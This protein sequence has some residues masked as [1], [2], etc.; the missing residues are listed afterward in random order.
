MRQLLTQGLR[1]LVKGD[2][3]YP[4]GQHSAAVIAVAT[5]KGGVGK[6]TSAVHLACGLARRPEAPRVLLIDLDAQGHSASSL[7]ACMPAQPLC[8]PTSQVLL[9]DDKLEI[10]DALVST[11]LPNLDL[12]PA[13]PALAEAEGRISQK[14]GK[15]L[16]LRDALNATRT[17]YDYIIID[18][19]PNK[20]NLTLNALLAAD[21]VLIPTDLSPLA[22]QGADEL[23]ATVVTVNE[24]LHHPLSVLGILITRVDH[25]NS[26]VNDAMR[27]QLLEAWGELL[28]HTEIGI[29]THISK[30][31]MAGLPV[32]SFAPTSRASAHYTAL[33]DEVIQRLRTNA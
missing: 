30:A 23:V 12:T 18:C 16:L 9:S 22:L 10:L 28:F 21:H 33:V 20:G 2:P 11:K 1:R 26:S 5:V 3:R 13:D 19:P 31:Q 15:E 29:N 4:R 7:S 17:H 27:K 32:F 25:R 8:K 14:I 6:T 24:R